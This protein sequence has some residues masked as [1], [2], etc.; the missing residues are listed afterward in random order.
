MVIFLQCLTIYNDLSD[1]GR[2]LGKSGPGY[3]INTSLTNVGYRFILDTDGRGWM[4][5]E[6]A[7]PRPPDTTVSGNDDDIVEE[8]E[9]AC[10]ALL[11]QNGESGTVPV[12]A[13]DDDLRPG[14][15]AFPFAV[16]KR[17][18][19]VDSPWT[20]ADDRRPLLIRSLV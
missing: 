15:L 3:D 17:L 1:K 7:A 14:S 20:S 4:A 16:G 6:E 13:F 12:P 9:N 19:N 2:S 18:F 10:A 8:T 11:L 5:P